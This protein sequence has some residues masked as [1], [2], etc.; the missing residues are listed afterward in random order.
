MIMLKRM[1][2]GTCYLIKTK[3][4]SSGGWR[5]GGGGW[6][7]VWLHGAQNNGPVS[8]GTGCDRTRGSRDTCSPLEKQRKI[9]DL[10][11]Q[12]MPIL[13]PV[14][15]NIAGHGRRGVFSTNYAWPKYQYRFTMRSFQVLHCLLAHVKA[16]VHWESVMASPYL[17]PLPPRRRESSDEPGSGG[18]EHMPC[19]IT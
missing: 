12:T 7:R 18:W 19:T 4:K 15:A 1:L 6:G 9:D 11:G 8:R 5:G 14:C 2:S 13:L 10:N 17:L 3:R 16:V